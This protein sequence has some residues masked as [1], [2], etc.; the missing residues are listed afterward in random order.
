MRTPSP[1]RPLLLAVG[2]PLIA[3]L[4]GCG[5]HGTNQGSYIT[6]NSQ[7]EPVAVADRGGIVPPEFGD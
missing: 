4:A 7:V 5:M 3:A 2:L 6:G 1:V